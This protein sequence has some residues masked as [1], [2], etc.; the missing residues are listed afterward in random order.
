MSVSVFHGASNSNSLLVL[1]KCLLNCV[2]WKTRAK[3]E[4]V[5]SY[6]TRKRNNLKNNREVSD[7][8]SQNTIVNGFVITDGALRKA[9]LTQALR[10]YWRWQPSG[11]LNRVVS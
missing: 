8:M 11:P 3:Q 2:S 10:M 7:I 9:I 4:T 1:K 5:Y 6:A